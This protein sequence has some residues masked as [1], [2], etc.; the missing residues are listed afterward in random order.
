MSNSEH[1]ALRELL[2]YGTLPRPAPPCP[3][4]PYPT[5][6]YPALPH[7]TPPYPTPPYPT[8]PVVIHD[9]IEAMSNSEHRALRELLSYGG[10]YEVI[11]L[12]VNCSCRLV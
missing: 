10:L 3:A 6:P 12:E 5:P 2:S 8:L 9:G 11:G 7:P 1:R 4:L